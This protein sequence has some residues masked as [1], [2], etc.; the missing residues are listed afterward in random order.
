MEASVISELLTT[1]SFPITTTLGIALYFKKINEENRADNREREE[2]SRKRENALIDKL[3]KVND[4][5]KDLACMG[6]E[7]TK[8]N[9][10][11]SLTNSLL[12][13]DMKK[14]LCNIDDK[15]DELMKLK[16]EG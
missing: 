12:A 13:K 16:K 7:L 11:I 14:E 5:N 8:T 9:S 1:V 2:E 3:Q 6:V 4:T 15:I 10:E